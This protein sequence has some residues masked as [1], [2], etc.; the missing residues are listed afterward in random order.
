MDSLHHVAITVKD[1]PR[2]IQW[3]LDRFDCQVSYQDD[4]WAMLDFANIQLALVLP[5]QHPAHIALLQTD[6]DRHGQL[7]THRDGVQS[8]Y[9][10]D[11][12]GNVIE[13]VERGSITKK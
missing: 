7:V 4:T 1:L 10:K 3:Y 9:I 2:A 5:E 11:S 12:E 8:V 6:A 13:I